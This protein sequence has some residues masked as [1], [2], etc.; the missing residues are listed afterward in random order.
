MSNEKGPKLLNKY[1][2]FWVITAFIIMVILPIVAFIMY[3]AR[4]FTVQL[5]KA[6]QA[7][8]ELE[9]EY[10]TIEPFPNSR[11]ERYDASHKTSHALVGATYTNNANFDEIISYYNEQLNQHGWQYYKTEEIKDWGTDLGGKTAV[12]CKGDYVA[13]LQYAGEKANYGWTY[14]FDLTWGLGGCEKR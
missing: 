9:M 12:Y 2:Y 13:S 7:M 5:P 14:G 4:E 1:W 10:K 3:I 8:A 11:I 6:K